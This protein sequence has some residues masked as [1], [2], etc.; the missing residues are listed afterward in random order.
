MK[1]RFIKRTVEGGYD[2]Q[3]DWL[4]KAKFDEHTKWVKLSFIIKQK[5]YGKLNLM[6]RQ[7]ERIKM[8]NNNFDKSDYLKSYKLFHPFKLT[9]YTSERCKLYITQPSQLNWIVSDVKNDEYGPNVDFKN[10]TDGHFLFVKAEENA[11]NSSLLK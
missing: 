6:D 5:D 3:T 1:V 10:T 2:L 4:R 11:G 9:L 7:S 8:K